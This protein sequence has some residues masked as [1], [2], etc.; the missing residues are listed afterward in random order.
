MGWT[1]VKNGELLLLASNNFDVF[2][3]VDTNLH[4]QQNVRGLRIAVILL[5]V[6]T[7]RLADLL[8]LVPDLLAA[9]VSARQGAITVVGA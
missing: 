4:F 2:I 9:I 5:R 7:N 8:P 6:R 3:T 1:A